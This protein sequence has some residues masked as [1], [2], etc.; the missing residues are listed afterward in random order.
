MRTGELLGQ[1]VEMLRVA[2]NGKGSP[3]GKIAMHLPACFKVV[4]PQFIMGGSSSLK[5]YFICSSNT[6]K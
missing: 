1:P 2:C 5:E 4:R 6:V 3:L